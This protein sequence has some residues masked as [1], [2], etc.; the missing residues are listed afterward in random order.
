ACVVTRH[1]CH[2]SPGLLQQADQAPGWRRA[3]RHHYEHVLG[4][5]FVS[6]NDCVRWAWRAL[7]YPKSAELY[8]T[9]AYSVA[10]IKSSM[11]HARAYNRENILISFAGFVKKCVRCE[12][13]SGISS[14]TIR[15]V[16]RG[17]S[18][19]LFCSF[20]YQLGLPAARSSSVGILHFVARDRYGSHLI[21][22]A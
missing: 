5:Q 19:D 4:L 22:P 3:R 2:A 8:S 21:G 14:F 15:V 13:C 7:A 16:P 17:K 9:A 18:G 11:S 10:G 20:P 12:Y 1:A 6:E